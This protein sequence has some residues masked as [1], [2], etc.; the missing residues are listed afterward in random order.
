[1]V[2]LVSF[3]FVFSL[4]AESVINYKI[5]YVESPYTPENV[6]ELLDLGVS[7]DEYE[8]DIIGDTPLISS[9]YAPFKVRRDYSISFEERAKIVKI[10]LKY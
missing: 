5:K 2:S 8:T 3:L 6:Q 7:P 9:M 1:I 10:L 4:A